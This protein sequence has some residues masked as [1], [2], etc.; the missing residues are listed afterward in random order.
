VPERR[1]QPRP[2]RHPQPSRRRASRAGPGCGPRTVSGRLISARR[3]RPERAKRSRSSPTSP[4]GRAATSHTTVPDALARPRRHHRSHPL[5]ARTCTCALTSR[6]AADIQHV[7]HK[8]PARACQ[9]GLR[10]RIT[11]PSRSTW[12]PPCI[13][14]AVSCGPLTVAPAAHPLD[15]QRCRPTTPPRSATSLPPAR[16][17]SCALHRIFVSSARRGRREAGLSG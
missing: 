6:S 16:G 12:A 8:V 2:N 11:F 7:L 13:P 3:A 9:S 5:G 15:G 10:R 14:H 17:P 1:G 4:T